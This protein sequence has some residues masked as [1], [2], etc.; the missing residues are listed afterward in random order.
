MQQF[1]TI[2]RRRTQI[3][4]IFRTVQKDQLASCSQLNVAGQ[5]S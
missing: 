5:F 3:L 1:E 2:A 4:Q